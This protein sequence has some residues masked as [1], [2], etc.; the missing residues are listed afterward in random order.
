MGLWMVCG[1]LLGFNWIVTWLV[2]R[3]STL[4]GI[5]VGLIR[6]VKDDVRIVVIIT[7]HAC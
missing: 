5:I 2:G 1:G 6:S 7:T 4:G 3:S